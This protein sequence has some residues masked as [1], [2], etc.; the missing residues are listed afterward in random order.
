MIIRHGEKPAGQ[1][2]GVTGQGTPDKKSL[3]V[4][5]WIR[6]G[7]LSAL[8]AP[9]EGPLRPGLFRPRTVFAS[10]RR[11]PG[12]GSEREQETVRPLVRRLGLPLDTDHG[13]GEESA[14]VAAA[15]E[16]DGP[17]LICWKHDYIGAIVDCLEG[18]DP[19]PPRSWPEER[20]DVV[21]VFAGTPGSGYRFHQVPQLLL[22]DDR[23]TPIG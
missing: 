17:V 5:G 20:Y 8:F 10:N 21:W 3:T 19:V 4:A 15:E 14:L 1:D 9:A 11:G 7:A 22:A 16:A 6:A 13:V 12:G 23:A 2:R 18:V